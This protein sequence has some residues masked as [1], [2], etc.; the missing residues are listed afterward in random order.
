MDCTQNAIEKR[1]SSDNQ[2]LSRDELADAQ[3]KLEGTKCKDYPRNASLKM[4][5]NLSL[6]LGLMLLVFMLRMTYF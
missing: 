1:C 4:S 2:Q 3:T 5:Q 6:V